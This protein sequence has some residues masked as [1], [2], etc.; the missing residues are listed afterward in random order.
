MKVG[1]LQ[2]FVVSPEES[3]Q[4]QSLAVFYQADWVRVITVQ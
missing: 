3:G 2:G 1:L 4:N